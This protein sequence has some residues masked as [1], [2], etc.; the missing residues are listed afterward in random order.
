MKGIPCKHD[1]A[2]IYKNLERLED[3]VHSCYRKDAYMFAYK[4]MI[5][6][7]LSQDEWIETNQ[8]APIAPIVYKSLGKPSMKRKKDI[9][10]PNNPYK[11][12]R[13]YRPIKCGFCYQEGH[14]SR[15]CKTGIISETP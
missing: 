8:L 6:P 3:Y 12:S 14:N 15:R 11:V 7:L 4:E 2:T 10:E 13:S 9:D 1:V 5:T